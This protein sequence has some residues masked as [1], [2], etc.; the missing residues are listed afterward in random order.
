MHRQKIWFDS[1]FGK[2]YSCSGSDLYW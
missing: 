1:I 2:C